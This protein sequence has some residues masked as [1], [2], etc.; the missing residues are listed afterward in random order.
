MPSAV[1]KR[2]YGSVT[3]FWL[4]R[5]AVLEGLKA[6]AERLLA[7][8]PEI[9]RAIV[10]GSIANDRAVPGSDADVFLL[11][12]DPMPDET[13]GA[14]EENAPDPRRQRWIDRPLT[15][16]P[17]FDDVGLPVELFC[18]TRSEAQENKIAA[19]AREEG[20]VLAER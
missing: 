3:V 7:E 10:F 14:P 19:R 9:R 2:S 16:G 11:L 20:I 12:D 8:R 17:F 13:E 15:Y 1:R 6:A 5:G 4:D 18:Y